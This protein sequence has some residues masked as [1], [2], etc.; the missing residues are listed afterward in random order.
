M[1]PDIENKYSCCNEKNWIT[2]K[3]CHPWSHKYWLA[4]RYLETS[5][6]LVFGGCSL[7]F[8]HKF[9]FWLT[10]KIMSTNK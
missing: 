4:I 10:R 6:V 9:N 3:W 7:N 1:K 5:D 2:R 8:L